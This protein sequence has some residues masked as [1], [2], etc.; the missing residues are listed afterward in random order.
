ALGLNP[1]QPFST[2]STYLDIT[3]MGT[4]VGAK[5]G[6]HEVFNKEGM[7]DQKNVCEVFDALI[8]STSPNV[9]AATVTTS[10]TGYL[11]FKF[12]RDD[13]ASCFK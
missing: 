12:K 6:Q 10:I 8:T 13:N 11:N 1:I 2:Q 7:K 9:T 4:S 3:K 5:T